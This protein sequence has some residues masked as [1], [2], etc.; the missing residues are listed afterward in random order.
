[1][2]P[3]NGALDLRE[4]GKSKE[5]EPIYLDRRLF[6]Q[7][8]AYGN[9]R[10]VGP[11]IEALE[12]ANIV[13]T[14]YEDINDPQGVGLLTVTENPD[15]FVTDLRQLL[16]RSPFSELTPKPEYTMMG[17]TYALGY[18]NDLE[19]ALINRP[20]EKAL[21]PKMS[22]AVWY[23]LRRAGSFEQLSE[24]EQ[25]KILREHGGIGFTFGRAGY[26][27]DI[28]LA[29]FGLD[30]NDNDFMVAVLGPELYP[31]SVVVQTMRKTRQT[32]QYLVSLGPFFIG[33]AVWQS[34]AVPKK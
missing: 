10:N 23:P 4:K 12:G 18:E 31:L 1:M 28:R 9:C 14:L 7:L 3:E 15:F 11:L 22:W 27:T 26:A 34:K 13:G 21:D 29:C 19:Q 8:L 33:K 25:Q 17:R 6:M 20:R 2:M 32:S 30:K 16:N 5:G 24:Q